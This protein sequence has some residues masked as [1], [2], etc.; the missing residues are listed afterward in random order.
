M[1]TCSR[2]HVRRIT[3]FFFFS[4]V[5]LHT[6]SPRQ[7]KVSWKRLQLSARIPKVHPSPLYERVGMASHV[8]M[9]ACLAQW[10]APRM[11]RESVRWSEWEELPFV[12]PPHPHQRQS[13]KIVQSFCCHGQELPSPPV[14]LPRR[15]LVFPPSWCRF[16]LLSHFFTSWLSLGFV[17]FWAPHTS[18]ALPIP[19]RGIHLVG[20]SNGEKTNCFSPDVFISRCVLVTLELLEG[21]L[22]EHFGPS[23][24]AG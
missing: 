14:V 22:D 4:T 21:R 17:E 2:W 23:P 8:Q 16:C 15:R 6:Q 12:P 13:N 10:A 3:I 1:P 7:E 18:A 24:A 20:S 5:V 9:A 19:A 11:I